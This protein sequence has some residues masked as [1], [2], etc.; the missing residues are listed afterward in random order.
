[1]CAHLTDAVSMSRCGLR[2]ERLRA[3]TRG[4]ARC[5]A[6]LSA[7]LPCLPGST[8]LSSELVLLLSLM[9]LP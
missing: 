5:A 2:A 3:W 6:I 8:G 9:L 1:M 7:A 4:R